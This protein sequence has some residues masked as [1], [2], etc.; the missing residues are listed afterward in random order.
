MNNHPLNLAVRFAL[1]LILLYIFGYWAFH[2]AP[3]AKWLLAFLLPLAAA[4]VWGVFRVEGDPSTAI[5]P[6]KGFVRL[7]I[8]A[9][10]FGSAIAMLFH[11][12]M[13]KAAWWLL[14]IS[15]LHNIVSYDRVWKLLKM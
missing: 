5:V 11:L 13:P 8:E 3:A 1:E 12:Q 10:L 6:V 2:K 9:I 15:L 7:S 4:A 14:G